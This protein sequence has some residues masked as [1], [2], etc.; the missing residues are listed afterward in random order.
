MKIILGTAQFGLDY[1]ITNK[2]GQVS[3]S[4][5][6][7]ILDCA[8]RYNIKTLDTASG[9]GNS[10]EILGQAGVNEYQI[11]TKTIPLKNG[12]NKVID[13]FYKSL[14]RLDKCQV[15]GLLNHDIGDIENQHFDELM[16]KLTKLK[17]EGLVK[18]IGF[19]TYTPE[20]IDLLLNNFDFDLIQVPFNVFDNRL[21]KGGQ[22]TALKN[23]KIEIHAR[24][25]FLQGV[26]LNFDNLS[27]Y[28]LKWRGQMESYQLMVKESGMSLLEYAINYAQSI[29]E[30]DKIIVGVTN[31][32]QLIEII[33]S[34][35]NSS[36]LNAY[37]INDVNLLNPN[38]WNR[39]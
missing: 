29:Q 34:L 17:K 13:S 18:K 36:N 4:E 6:K 32:N 1:G 30:I 14:E 16:N 24:S 7:N 38:L 26:L 20:Q 22:L 39:K 27:E 23:N 31:K 5:V 35:K 28:F 19:S 37:E 25:I 3:K 21:I 15:E 11:I 12:I 10:E 8:S 33:K 2:S 9:Y